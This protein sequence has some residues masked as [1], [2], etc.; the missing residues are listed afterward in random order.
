MDCYKIT[1]EEEKHRGMQYKDGLNVDVVPFDPTG[2][3]N[4]GGIYFAREDIL[5]FLNY[6]CWIRKVTIP[7]GGE[8]YT[9]PSYPWKFKAHSVIL[10]PRERITGDVVKR[11]VAEG[12]CLNGRGDDRSPLRRACNGPYTDSALA[13]IEAGADVNSVSLVT[14]CTYGRV[15]VLKAL[16][17]AGF[18]VGSQGAYGLRTACENDHNEIIDILMA[19]GVSV[20][21]ALAVDAN[22]GCKGCQKIEVKLESLRAK[23]E[24]DK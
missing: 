1:N 4:S 13:L 2:D 7:E 17:A 9:N 22:C 14:I 16:I 24:G 12:A 19:N 20:E 6:G 18:D 3:C 10:G 21:S 11:L 15:E 8:V 23:K 5:F